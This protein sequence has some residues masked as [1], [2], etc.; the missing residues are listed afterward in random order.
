M[1]LDIVN[2][3]T[4]TQRLESIVGEA[5]V[6]K[7]EESCTLYA[8]DIFT[9]AKSCIA[10]VKPSNKHELA[11]A[12]KAATQ[13]G[14]DV[15]PRGGGMSYTSGYV[16]VNDR[17][18]II[19]LGR[20]TR[21]LEINTQDMYVTVEAGCT[22]KQLY[23]A[24]VGTGYRTPYWGTLSGTYSTIGG[25][26]S[27]NAVF[28]GSGQYGSAADSVIGLEV[29]IADGSIV[30]TGSGAQLN[31]QPFFR[32]FGPDLTGLFTGDCGAL[33]FKATATIRLIKQF[34]GKAFCAYDFKT[35][36]DTINAMSE[37]SRQGLA[38]ECFGFDPFLQS[39]RLKRESLTKDVKALAGV[40]KAS[41]SVFG[42]LKDGAKVALAGRRYMDDVDFS[43]QLMIEGYTQCE[44][45]AK[46]RKVSDI[47]VS[48]NGREISNSIPKIARANPFGPVNVMLGPEGERWVCTHALVSHSSAVASHRAIL[49][50][51]AM[52]KSEFEKYGVETGF[53]FAL[54]ST[55]AFVLEPVFFW[56]DAATEI[57]EKYIESDHFVKL[58][59]LKEDLD[60]RQLVAKVRHEL[61]AMFRDVGG[62]HMQIGKDY[63]YADG[64]ADESLAL[65]KA[66]KAAV[67]P[68]NQ[69]NPGALGLGV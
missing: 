38:M 47:A 61:A 49:D 32:H 20:M 57:H 34:E 41:G 40:M 43:M 6:L 69:I 37:I 29:V 22:W 7:D 36:E 68:N 10:V 9:R 45:D 44:A 60:A 33:G 21:V 35:S 39:Q 19:D 12:V 50:V 42:A 67:D 48:F 18:I 51:F 30:T 27:Q 59:K 1:S 2:R 52:Y 53:L 46:A 25:G 5:H 63:H 8:Q 16:P 28:W 23:E 3:S 26:L 15:I 55:N 24:L 17:S 54:V 4:L 64:I 11:A 31:S 66:I 14:F 62:V 58:P 56:P 13:A 65:V